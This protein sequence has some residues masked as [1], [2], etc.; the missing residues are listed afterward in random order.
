MNTDSVATQVLSQTWLSNLAGLAS[1][2]SS[3]RVEVP[4][5]RVVLSATL[6]KGVANG[7]FDAEV[8]NRAEGT[9]DGRAWVI[10]SLP[11][12]RF[13][14]PSGASAGP[15]KAHTSKTQVDFAFL[16]V[17]ATIAS[18]GGGTVMVDTCLTFFDT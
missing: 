7:A 15:E 16:R 3:G 9:Y 17:P 12:L 13:T 10:T 5:N 18:E 8:E 2:A 4:K 1:A 14:V 6:L 11:V